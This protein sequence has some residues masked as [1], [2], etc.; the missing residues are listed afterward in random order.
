MQE[1]IGLLA[2]QLGVS[3][4]QAQGGAGLLFKAAQEKLGG[5]FSQVAQKV[6]GVHDLIKAAP[7]AGGAGGG[8][9][10]LLGGLASAVG[11]DAGKA[12]GNAGGLAQLAGGF[13]S[14]KLDPQMIGKFVPVI[15]QFVQSKYGGE[16]VALLQKA[17][18]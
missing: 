10:S 9:G 6:E 7:A 5:D 1:L 14:L 17:L 2:K 4:Q 11:G 13:S 8:L 15:L 16:I 18:K 12:L 3:E